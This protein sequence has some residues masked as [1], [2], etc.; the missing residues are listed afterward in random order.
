MAT[1]KR[2]YSGLSGLVGDSDTE[3]SRFE[4]PNAMP[5]PDSAAE[6]MPP[7]KKG[8]GRPKATVSKVINTKASARR[9]SGAKA[10]PT[11][12][13]RPALKDK[14]N[15]L[16][17]A[18]DTEEVD[19]FDGPA[20][21]MAASGDELDDSVLAVKQ[22]KVTKPAAKTL[23]NT[24]ASKAGRTTRSSIGENIQVDAKKPALTKKPAAAKRAPSVKSKVKDEVIQ[25]SQQQESMM[26][27][28]DEDVVIQDEPV[29]K[30]SEVVQR[31]HSTKSKPREQVI[32]ETQDSMIEVD[33][34]DV[35]M[36]DE[37]SPQPILRQTNLKQSTSQVRPAQI[38]RRRA[39]SASDSERD[40]NTRR[41]LGEMT[42]KL[43][44]LDL[45]Y[46]NLREIGVTQA[47]QKFEQLRKQHEQS[48]KGS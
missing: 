22:K 35:D 14:T 48:K 13:G 33:D 41:K 4:Q 24:K 2:G 30:K 6:N 47:D 38:P 23:R 3:E 37:L 25:E 44:N 26:E 16:P 36:A 1:S 19:E 12:K 43:E 45:K 27:V 31:T 20:D 46:R 15:A 11:K 29:A 34:G 17:D 5:T 21:T 10:G 8:R 40:P 42:K 28:D 39:G 7:A 18:D 32:Q 9:V